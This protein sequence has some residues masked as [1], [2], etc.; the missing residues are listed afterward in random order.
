MDGFNTLLKQ[1]NE[2]DE[3]MKEEETKM[4]E[5]KFAKQL[6]ALQDKIKQD[7]S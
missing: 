3:Q 4:L 1:K 5:K 7:I 6:I 2:T